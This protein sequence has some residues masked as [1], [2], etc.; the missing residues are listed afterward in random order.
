M[1]VHLIEFEDVLLQLHSCG[2]M[3]NE[4][5]YGHMSHVEISAHNIIVPLQ[6]GQS[7]CCPSLCVYKRLSPF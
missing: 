2:Q 7:G 1:C 6:V 5:I 4:F 3:C